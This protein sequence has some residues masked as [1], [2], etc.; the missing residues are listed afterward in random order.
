MHIYVQTSLT[1]QMTTRFCW[2]LPSF[3][4]D[5]EVTKGT[6]L[7][8]II[9]YCWP[10]CLALTARYG[11]ASGWTILKGGDV[12]EVNTSSS[13][14]LGDGR[15][16]WESLRGKCQWKADLLQY[17]WKWCDKWVQPLVVKVFSVMAGRGRI[18]VLCV[19]IF[20]FPSSYLLASLYLD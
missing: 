11:C 9:M 1:V 7:G 8:C 14:Q 6:L 2:N 15:S 5:A 13:F 18:W 16:V 20:S 12:E 17:L 19:W 4:S 3:L 10:L